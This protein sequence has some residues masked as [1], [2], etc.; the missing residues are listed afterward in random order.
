MR[1]F[2]LF[3]APVLTLAM[4]SAWAE[5]IE[6][7]TGKGVSGHVA[8][9]YRPGSRA[10]AAAP[11]VTAAAERDVRWICERLELKPQKDVAV[12]V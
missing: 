1:S 3:L 7:H 9:R 12:Y 2:V 11:R 6:T 10:G 4:S 5:D 8:V